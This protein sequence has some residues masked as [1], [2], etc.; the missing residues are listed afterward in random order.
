LQFFDDLL[1]PGDLFDALR[2]FY[3]LFDLSYLPLHLFLPFSTLSLAS[4]PLLA[5]RTACGPTLR[6][7]GC[8]P[9]FEV[10]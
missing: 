7:D 2:L 4:P 10:F 6:V 5:D 1:Q 3:H 9:V 8:L